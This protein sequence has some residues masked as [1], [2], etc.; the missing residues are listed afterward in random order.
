VTTG[1]GLTA[2]SDITASPDP[3]SAYRRLREVYGM[4]APV[5][6]EAGVTAWLVMGWKEIC[7]VVRHE[8]FFSRDPHNWGDLQQGKVA[9][10]SGL[11]P[12]MF[13]R[14]NAYFKDGADHHRLRAPLDDGIRDLDQRQLRVSV[15]EMC[16]NL[17]A[18]F[19]GRGEA[20]LVS[21]YAAVIP[22]L[23][24]AGLFGLDD[25][26]RNEL[27]RAIAALFS[28][29]EDAQAG[30]RTIEAIIAECMRSHKQAPA[31]DLTTAFQRHPNLRDDG[32]VAQS[33]LL[34]ITAGAETTA[35]WIAQALR[36]M[37]T[38]DRFRGKV[39]GW[40]PGTDDAL[41]QVLW[42]EPPMANMPARYALCDT[43]LAGQPIRRGDAIILGLMAAGSDPRY[44]AADSWSEL[45]NR[46][47][48]AWS[49]G[50]HACPAE[51]PAR[52]ITRAAVDTALRSLP[53]LDLAAPGEELTL[54]PSPWT[55]G[56]VSLPVTFTPFDPQPA[57]TPGAP[58]WLPASSPVPG[59]MAAGPI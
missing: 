44:H 29:G 15:T 8:R 32:E 36:I 12:M 40:R 58:A 26:R 39:G 43:E 1:T 51:V 13:P 48:L 3:Q 17:I 4:V 55:R 30:N 33:M 20:D 46:S 42:R 22:I 28:S 54:R 6:L 21:E 27:Q 14:D 31:R 18:R 9:P 25:T 52:I 23:A 16:E 47:H 7:E 57:L 56:P 24:V 19:A 50:P 5:E 11:G 49:T 35:I 2:L 10:D 38:L 45:G 37:L 53:G 59:D 34:M 41:D